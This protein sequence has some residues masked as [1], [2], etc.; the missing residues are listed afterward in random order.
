MKSILSSAAYLLFLIFSANAVYNDNGL[1]TKPIVGSEETLEGPFKC[2]LLC[3]EGSGDYDSCMRYC[4]PYGNVNNDDLF[5]D[6]L[7][8]KRKYCESFYDNGTHDGSYAGDLVDC[9]CYCDPLCNCNY[10]TCGYGPINA[11]G[12]QGPPKPGCV[13][14]GFSNA[15]HDPSPSE[16]PA[17]DDD[18]PSPSSPLLDN[19]SST[20][21]S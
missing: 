1:R 12:T 15:S 7:E 4:G 17:P 2:A 21:T 6:Y 16:A 11:D 13:E 10:G 19:F 8:C 20:S 18:D 14:C 9:D 3:N 5:D